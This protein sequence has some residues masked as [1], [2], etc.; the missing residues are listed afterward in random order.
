MANVKHT[1]IPLNPNASTTGI[2]WTTSLLITWDIP[3]KKVPII[4][5]K[6]DLI[7]NFIEVDLSILIFAMMP[8]EIKR[9]IHIN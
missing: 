7:E 8:P 1:P 5:I 6:K 2:S 4:N 9:K 3:N